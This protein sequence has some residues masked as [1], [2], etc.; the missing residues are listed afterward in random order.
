MFICCLRNISLPVSLYVCMCV[1]TICIYTDA[2][3]HDT[4]GAFPPRGAGRFGAGREGVVLLRSVTG[5][6]LSRTAIAA[7]AT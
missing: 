3:W 2:H 7:A 1:S 6:G 5:R 4:N